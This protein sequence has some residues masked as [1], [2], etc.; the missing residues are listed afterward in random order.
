MFPAQMPSLTLRFRSLFT[1]PLL[2]LCAALFAADT[3][4]RLANQRELF[5][6][7]AVL[8]QV[9]GLDVRL[10][11][12]APAGVV[13]TFDEPWEGRFCTFVSILHDG[14]KYRMYYR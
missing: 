7:D 1:L 5:L 4:L 8:E 12:P 11:T 10:G 3:P 9:H 14:K 13:M 6:D 2:S